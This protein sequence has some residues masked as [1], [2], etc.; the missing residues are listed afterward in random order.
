[1]EIMRDREKCKLYLSQKR[2]IEKVIHRFN[3]QN[4]K[5]VRTPLAAHFKL[6][7][8]L[9]RKTDDERDYMFR[10]PYSSAIG[11]LMYAM[12][13]SRPDLSYAVS[14]VS[15]YMANPGKEHWKAVQLIFIYLHGSAVCLQ[16]RQN[17]DGVLGYVDSDL[18][19]PKTMP[20]L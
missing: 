20:R 3:V 13:C 15:K 14:A 10:V 4:A 5:P 2:Y 8:T 18:L 19:R 6:T 9:S 7:T 16:F 12:A 1:M 17:R 11:Y